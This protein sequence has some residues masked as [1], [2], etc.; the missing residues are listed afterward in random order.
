MNPVDELARLLPP[1]PAERA[2]PQAG[3]RRAELLAAITRLADGPGPGLRPAAAGGL[4]ALAWPSRRVAGASAVVIAILAIATLAV[5]V[6]RLMHSRASSP[7]APPGRRLTGPPAPAGSSLTGP[8]HWTVQAVRFSR[9]VASSN[10]GSVIVTAGS[11]SAAAVTATPRYQGTAPVLASSLSGGTLTITATCPDDER[12]QVT[13]QVTV[14]AGD[15]VAA[16]SGQGDVRLTGLSAGATATSGQGDISLT[17]LTGTVTATDGQGDI[18][19]RAIHGTLS[20]RDEQ[21][22]VQVTGL[23]GQLTASSQQGDVTLSQ[24]SGTVAAHSG[25]G[26][27]S[28][29]G[30]AVS[31]A[32]LT[33][34]ESDVSGS[35][36]TP[37]G[38]VVATTQL[39]SV[40]VR[41]PGGTSYDVTARASLGGASV[42]APQS[43]RSR[44]VVRASSQLGSVAVTG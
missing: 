23:S 4:R 36:V 34:Q 44:H 25:Q 29:T 14:P 24:I 30:L 17:R 1:A 40:T 18:G 22:D 27:V 41:L 31:R 38:L 35:F 42:T 20:A 10:T 15:H 28:A 43:A 7:V 11:A 5:A 12:C 19:A 3:E 9:V 32:T 2:L 33:S 39:G 26:T 8:R 13:V 6:P 37:P 21:G 16:S